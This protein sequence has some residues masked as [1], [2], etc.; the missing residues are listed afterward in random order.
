MMS[1]K[2]RPAGGLAGRTASRKRAGLK[3]LS[4]QGLSPAV[5]Y[6]PYSICDLE[7]FLGLASSI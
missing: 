6:H 1:Q 4:D 2:L 7:F 5:T 3:H